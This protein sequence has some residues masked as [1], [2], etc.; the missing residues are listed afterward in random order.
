MEQRGLHIIALDNVNVDS[1]SN[2]RIKKAD[3]MSKQNLRVVLNCKGLKLNLK[4]F[5]RSVK[6]LKKIWI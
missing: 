5:E 1:F 3:H 2:C 4:N 6:G